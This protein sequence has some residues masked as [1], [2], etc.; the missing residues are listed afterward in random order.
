MG[1]HIPRGSIIGAKIKVF[2]DP[3]NTGGMGMSVTKVGICTTSKESLRR[4][5][6]NNRTSEFAQDHAWVGDSLQNKY[7]CW[8]EYE[9]D[10]KGTTQRL[11]PGT[12]GG[13]SKRGQ[14]PK[15]G[16]YKFGYLAAGN[17]P[18]PTRDDCARN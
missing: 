5:A 9:Y 18:R 1:G 17:L 11:E 12:G 16:A 6:Y 10:R 2:I 8:L 7:A 3:S 14:Q 4:I 15:A 13:N